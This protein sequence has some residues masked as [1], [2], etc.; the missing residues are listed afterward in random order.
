MKKEEDYWRNVANQYGNEFFAGLLYAPWIH[1]E[2]IRQLENS[3]V[4][5]PIS[6]NLN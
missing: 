3:I 5:I 1:E 6:E 4:Y 2:I